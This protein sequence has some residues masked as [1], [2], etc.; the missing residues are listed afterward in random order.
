MFQESAVYKREQKAESPAD[1]PLSPLAALVA[2]FFYAVFNVFFNA[3]FDA[4]YALG[5]F[6]QFV[7][8]VAVLFVTSVV[9]NWLLEALGV[10]PLYAGWCSLGLFFGPIIIIFKFLQW[11]H[12]GIIVINTGVWRTGMSIVPALRQRHL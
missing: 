1:V 4:L 2:K 10:E 6:I 8:I 12:R 7:C 11:P 5:L 3:F 9:V